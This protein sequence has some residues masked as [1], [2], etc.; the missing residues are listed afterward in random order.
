MLLGGVELGR[1]LGYDTEK[2]G[3]GNMKMF[4]PIVSLSPNMKEKT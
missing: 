3:R 1:V 4:S 2:K